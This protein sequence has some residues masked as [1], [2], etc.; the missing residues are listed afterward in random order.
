VDQHPQRAL[1]L[2]DR[3][4]ADAI[5]LQEYVGAGNAGLR[6]C[7]SGGSKQDSGSARTSAQVRFIADLGRAVDP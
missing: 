4:Q 7:G 5:E 6:F 1:T 2:L 3:M